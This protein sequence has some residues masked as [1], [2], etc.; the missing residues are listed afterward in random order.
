MKIVHCIGY[1]L[2]YHLG[3]TEVYVHSL[4]LAQS[5]AGNNV[6]I[7][8]PYYQIHIPKIYSYQ[9]IQVVGFEEMPVPTEEVKNGIKA[10]GGISNFRKILVDENPD[11][12]HFH[13]I[14]NSNGI[15]IFHFETA[16][17][18]KIKI[19]YTIHIALFTCRTGNLYYKNKDICDGKM[20]ELKCSICFLSN[21]GINSPFAEIASGV[22]LLLTGKLFTGKLK[23]VLNQ[24]K[25]TR[26]QKERNKLIFTYS[27]KIIVITEWYKKILEINNYPL[28]KI[29]YISQGLTGES[30]T[31]KH[32]QSNE[33]INFVYVGR[34]NKIKGID[35]LIQTFIS[36]ANEKCTLTIFSPPSNEDFEVKL[37]SQTDKFQNIYWAGILEYDL[38]VEK[39]SEFD[40][41]IIPS[42]CAEMS[43]LVIPQAFSAEIPVI[44]TNHFGIKEL[45]RNEIDGLLFDPKDFDNL[46]E[47]IV[48]IIANPSIL[49]KLKNSIVQQKSFEKVVIETNEVYTEVLKNAS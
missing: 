49:N 40:A 10:P 46:K 47:L 39:L 13:E 8:V 42:I 24:P 45:V 19:V 22:G 37:R 23:T 41:L 11:I 28:N 15:G 43:P 4:A 9:G 18:L 33:F 34:I 38:I 48:K 25:F 7:I 3:G 31:S 17:Q 2:P 26:W 35:K 21:K 27:S 20:N 16:F 12:I 30:K 29:K 5:K 32:S 44:G 6:K 36:L 14:S 1:Y